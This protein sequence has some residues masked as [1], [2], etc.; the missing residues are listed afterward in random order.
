LGAYESDPATGITTGPAYANRLDQNY[1]NPFNPTTTIE[2][3]IAE[4]GFVSL[5]VYDVAGQLVRTIVDEVQSPGQVRPVRW[6]G[7]NDRGHSVSSGVYFYK[8][9]A[10]DFTKTRKMVLLK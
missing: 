1:P 7:L 8:L 2:Y 10:A 5:K 6:N 9:T 4:T 3:S